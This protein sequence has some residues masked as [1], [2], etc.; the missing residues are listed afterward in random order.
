MRVL[1][2]DIGDKISGKLDFIGTIKEV[3]EYIDNSMQYV[4]DCINLISNDKVYNIV[5]K[6]EGITHKEGIYV[7][8]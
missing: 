3:S 1:D 2:Y 4:C 8:G 6:I 7:G 5:P